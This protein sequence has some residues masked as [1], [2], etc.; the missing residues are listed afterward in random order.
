MAIKA[1]ILKWPGITAYDIDF[2]DQDEESA[3]AS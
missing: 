2:R 3:S 1:R